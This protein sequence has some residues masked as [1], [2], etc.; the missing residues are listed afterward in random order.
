ML[1]V[2]LADRDFKA[3]TI[4]NLSQALRNVI[5]RELKENS[6]FLTVCKY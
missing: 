3:T 5:F 6:L 2:G 4:I 1:D